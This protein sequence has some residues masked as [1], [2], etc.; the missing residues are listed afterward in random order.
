MRKKKILRFLQVTLILSILAVW[1]QSCLNK[2]DST[3]RSDAVVGIITPVDELKNGDAEEFAEYEHITTIV[4]KIAHVIEYSIVGF[5]IMCILYLLGRIGIKDHVTCL[6][7]GLTVALIDETIQIFSSRGP[8]ISDLWV[9]LGGVVLG[10]GVAFLVKTI[11]I[12][13]GQR[14]VQE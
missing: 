8:L 14:T 3:V 13:A 7:A 5:Q 10:A 9:D 1:G 6:Y 4:R 12:R 11:V 2:A